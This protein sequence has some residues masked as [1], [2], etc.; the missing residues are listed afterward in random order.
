[1]GGDTDDEGT[2]R[3]T[4]LADPVPEPLPDPRPDLD[5]EGWTG[6]VPEFWVRPRSS[7]LVFWRS[8]A[9]QPE[10]A[11]PAL[12]AIA[13]LAGLSYGWGMGNFPLEPF[14]AGAARSMGSS[15]KDFFFAA[16][17]PAGTTSLDK[18]PGG[19]WPQALAV[20]LFGFHFWAVALPQVVAGV[21]TVLVVYRAVRR[22]VGP[23][24]GLV[25]ALIV[26]ASPVSALLNRGNVS[27]SLLILLTVLAADATGRAVTTGRLASLV[28]AGVW[29]GLAFQTKMLQAWLVLPAL[30][31]TYLVAGRPRLGRRLGHVALAGLVTVI[32]SL[33]WM[34]VVAVVP[35]HDRPFVDGTT[36]DSIYTQVFVYNGW[37]RFG[38]TA[39]DST[40]VHRE[41]PFLVA[42]QKATP[43]VGTFRIPA[44]VD[45][46]V[47]GPLGR[48]DGWLLLAAV[49]SAVGVLVARRSASRRDPVRAA[50]I[51]WGSWLVVLVGFFSG[52]AFINSYYTAALVPAVA[53]LCATGLA[54]AWRTRH[55]SRAS[56]LVLLAL[57]PLSV[58]YAVS[59]VPADS[60]VRW[61]AAVV[62]GALAVVAEVALVGSLRDGEGAPGG[63]ALAFGLAALALLFLPALTTGVV[64]VDGLGSFS[65]PYQS[66]A[67]TAGTTT[68]PEDYQAN[69]GT[70]S[71]V[72]DFR[73]PG[74]AIV[75][76]YDSGALA[77]P[78]IMITGKEFLPIGGY[79]GSD[80]SPTLRTLQ[81]L[82]A[83]GRLRTFVVPVNPAGHD[84]RTTWVRTHCALEQ[85]NPYGLSVQLGLYQ[86]TPRSLRHKA[87]SVPAPPRSGFV[88][89]P[90]PV[91]VRPTIEATEGSP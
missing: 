23:K 67:A 78:L 21:L 62:G 36:N 6:H 18:L 88:A 61:W 52:A 13:A 75:A 56:Q 34:S 83:R 7:R 72:L 43:Q 57:V 53:G 63:G 44:S 9:D 30:F 45:R 11:R 59:L 1:M 35:A 5:D 85:T 84:L 3:A 82:V 71:P 38:V 77:S 54:V 48:D 69:Y 51:L 15:W 58:L 42:A 64:V 20:R 50:A 80:P 28:M 4:A 65:T 91:A 39:D 55:S 40:I 33:S 60:P 37:A 22:L 73:Y 90:T 87:V 17:D 14:Y 89:P 12:V 41:Q 47:V 29:V 19:V 10:W 86:C 26:A 27:D 32:V 46:L 2:G 8:P 79:S 68:G 66:A 49:V 81:G 16:A 76:A 25:A 70:D 24:A 31:A 74:D